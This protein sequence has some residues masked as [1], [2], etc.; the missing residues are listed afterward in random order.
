[1]S[2]SQ[3]LDSMNTFPVH[4][5][6]YHWQRLLSVGV[7]ITYFYIFMEWVFF[8]TMP[9]FM[10]ALDA[11][12]RMAVLFISG[13]VLGLVSLFP[14]LCLLVCGLFFPIRLWKHLL[15]AASFVPAFLLACLGL[16]LIDNFTYTVFSFGIVSSRGVF[17]AVYLL[18]F[19]LLFLYFLR[20]MFRF[21][22]ADRKQGRPAR[23]WNVLAS[24]CLIV[25]TVLALGQFWL[26]SPQNSA[27][28]TEGDRLP[29]I[30]ILGSDGLNASHMSVYGYGRDTTPYLTELVGTSLLAENAFPN[31]GNSSGSVTSILTGKLPTQTGVLYS[32]NILTG[33]DS[34]QHLPNLLRRSGYTTVEIG[35]PSYVDSYAVN[36]QD[37][38][39]VVNQRSVDDAAVFRIGRR[40]GLGNTV[41]FLSRLYERISERLMHIF[42]V[43]T[44]QNSF[45]LVTEAGE[46][47]NIDDRER[48]DQLLDL[49][50]NSQRPLFLHVHLMG[51]HGPKF[52]PRKHI[53]SSGM[54]Q[55]ANWMIDYYDDAILDFD[56]YVRE[57]F[58]RLGRLGK[59]DNTIVVIYTDHNMQ[60]YTT[61]RIPLIFRFPQGMHA[62]RIHNNVQNLDIAPTLLD[63][64]GAPIPEWMAGQSLLQ[65]EPPPDRVIFSASAG[66]TDPP[67][68]VPPFYQF[69]TLGVVVCDR[70]YELHT[71]G[72]RWSASTV[73]GHTA[74]CNENFIPDADSIRAE[75]LDHLQNMDFDVQTLPSQIAYVLPDGEIPR[76]EASVFLLRAVY[77]PAFTPPPAAGIFTDVPDSNPYAPWAERV[78]Q[79]GMVEGCSTSP[80]EFCPDEVVTRAEAARMILLAKHGKG[81]IPPPATGIFADVPL[82]SPFAPW[83]EELYHQ[84]IAAGCVAKPLSY[85][86]QEAIHVNQL[87][88]LL[89][90]AFK[91]TLP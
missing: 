80:L 79:E 23:V 53:Y 78:F 58:T 13:G 6:R 68:Q 65:G 22:H 70:W 66:S 46:S 37:G 27:A 16:L 60:Y 90:N 39:D 10:D 29:N 41:Y 73:T 33:A 55:D 1:M 32:P 71:S 2:G 9:S 57:V 19:L 86:P 89:S 84:G 47:F 85:C 28:V 82:D 49:F 21:V 75:L 91:S 17:R 35:V 69:G 45:E 81:Y 42:F 24:V 48:V 56:S 44:M 31:A 3:K 76:A 54:D 61:K 18:V 30:L 38:F 40:L 59:L 20:H 77:G 12:S 63:Y 8:V 52:F 26:S 51:T 15:L 74:P 43:R 50:E 7:L 34:F 11:G 72:E 36:M 62:G 88:K 87:L 4:L 83:I 5:N 64:L 25:S 14:A 67:K